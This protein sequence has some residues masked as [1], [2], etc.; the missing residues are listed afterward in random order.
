MTAFS[1]SVDNRIARL[2]FD[3]PGEKVNK[4][5]ATVVTELNAIL[6][7]L[8]RMKD[9]RV[10]VLTSAKPDVFIAGADIKE[11]QRIATAE[12]G[13]GKAR[14]GQQLFQR[15]ADLPF[16]S[17]AVIDG[18]CLGG[19][20]ECALACTYRIVTDADKT[21]LG[22]PEVTL[23]ILPGWGGTQ[24]LPALVGPS[25][26]VDLILS[27][28]TMNGAKAFKAGLA[29]RLCA[30]AFLAATVAS[31]VEEIASEG[32]RAKVL[33]RRASLR[34][35][36]QTFI[37]GLGRPL[38]WSQAR[39]TLMR[40]TKGQMPAP[41][42]ALEVVKGTYGG[43]LAAGLEAEAR[44]FS[45]LAVTSEC[46]CLIDLFFA[47]EDA[48]KQ[49]G[50]PPERKVA[51]VGVLGAGVMGGGIAW[52]FAHKGLPVRVKDIG[53][54]AV[55]KAYKTVDE[56]SN[57]LVKLRK[58]TPGEARQR[59]LRVGGGVDWT[60]FATTDVVIEAVVENLE[61]KKKVLAEAETVVRDDC[62]LATNTSSL[63]VAD[64]AV[65]LQRPERLVGMHFFNP[66]NRMPLVEV[67][68]GPRSSPEAV[69]TIAALTRQS[70]KTAIVVQDCPGFLVNRI[71]LPYMNEAARCLTEGGD[72]EEIDRIILRYGMPM[73]PFEL[74]DVVGID[75]GHKVAKI[76]HEGYGERMAVAPILAKVHEELKLLG[77]KSGKGF[78]LHDGKRMKIN[79]DIDAAI[80][81]TQD[82]LGLKPRSVAAAEVLDRC[83]LIMVNE[84]ARCVDEGVVATPGL[85]DLA[86]IMGTGYPPQR[87]GPL[88]HA[89][90]LGA[91]EVVARLRRLAGQHGPRFE[92]CRLLVAMAEAKLRFFGSDLAPVLSRPASGAAHTA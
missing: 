63:R 76:L 47:N 1:L 7:E 12:E 92:P 21:S 56:Y 22:L 54:D 35:F 44:A 9:V 80:A 70:G 55:A 34:R 62:I 30:R 78:Y 52:L 53:W 60:G 65:A 61:V 6:D 2:V 74:T 82:D 27:G 24:R 51:S 64:M 49:G 8:A 16:P 37:D 10:L 25:L 31:F 87:G 5:S 89:D 17:V 86:M 59:L 58:L 32:G 29:D 26:A 91:A 73:G 23:G 68:A 46:R 66:V 45:R 83:L 41:I 71:L 77:K 84:A 81:G 14:A 19:G 69:A 79:P 40:K 75:V 85:L 90:S 67:V 48:K 43:P 38:L 3:L 72:V 39:K 15:L 57:Q 20:M 36:P 28:R 42:A 13:Y 50:K 4:F 33:A 88:H 11:L 18:A